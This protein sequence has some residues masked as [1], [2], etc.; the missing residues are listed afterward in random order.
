MKRVLSV[1]LAVCI[2]FSLSI[3]V[4]AATINVSANP[5]EIKAGEDVTVTLTAKEAM[6]NYFNFEYRLYFDD[7]K[8]DLK[9]NDKGESIGRTNTYVTVSRAK[10]TDSKGSYYKISALNPTGGDFSYAAGEYLADLIFTAKSDIASTADAKFELTILESNRMDDST[11]IPVPAGDTAGSAVTVTVP[12]AAQ[13]SKFSVAA[14][15]TTAS[16]TVGSDATVSLGV[17]NAATSNKYNSYYFEVSYDNTVLEYDSNN[18]GAAVSAANGKLTIAGY[19]AD[20]TAPIVLTFKGIKT[21]SSAVT[22]TRANIDEASK[23]DAQDAPAAEITTEAVKITVTAASYNVTLD[24]TLFNGADTV[25]GGTDYTFSANDTEH[26]DYSNVTATMGGKTVEVTSDGKGNYTIANVT[27]DL[28]ITIE[29]KSTLTMEV[30]VSKYV[31]MDN[32]TVFLVTVTGTPEEG[33]AFAYGDNV[34]YKTTAY[35]E[36]VYSWLVI[37][38]KGEAFTVATAEANIKE[39]SGTAE[40]VKQSYDVNETGVVDINDAQLTYDIYSGK[41]TD[42]EKV[43]VRKF[44]RADVNLDKAVNS[45]DAVAVVKNSR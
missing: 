45:T 15:T 18:A 14:S 24:K 25:T 28:V 17:T 36:N 22:I 9:V 11:G 35:G 19:G 38:D 21:G 33:K 29:K 3:G 1:L 12:P 42:F 6:E 30:T 16:T 10:F 13:T 34:M 23:A 37:V 27:G 5:S 4:F 20:R 8:F 7:S 44:L 32:K 26:Y 43:S 31:E 40:E 39:A 2:I 41:Y